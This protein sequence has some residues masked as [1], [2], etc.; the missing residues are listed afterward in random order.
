MYNVERGGRFM[1]KV[2]ILIPAYNVEPY[3][4]QCMDSV[5]NQT[6]KDIEIICINDGSTD[7][8]LEILNEY[9]KNDNRIV[10]VDKINE[11]Y[12]IGMNTAFSKA[13]G[14]YIGIVEPD[15]YVPL[16]MYEELYNIASQNDLDFVKAD[17]YRFITNENGE[18]VNTLFRLSPNA[19][20]YNKVF[21]P[22]E[23]PDAIR[24][25]MNTWSGIY[26]RSFLEENHIL[27]NTTPGASYQ[28]NGFWM[29]TFIFAK[30]AM[31]V[32][33]PYYMNRRDNQNSSVH[34]PNKVY[35]MNIEYDHI[36]DIF[37]QHP[38]LWERFKYMYWYKKY[39]SYDFTMKRIGDEFR[40]E[41]VQRISKEFKHAMDKG[42]LSPD[43]FTVKGWHDINLLIE[44]P[45]RFC[46]ELY[47]K[48]KVTNTPKKPDTFWTKVKRRIPAP[49]K[50]RIKELIGRG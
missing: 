13:T 12:G 25:V 1:P 39:Y 48:K 45:K 30:R 20:D 46:D 6:L 5:V 37:M 44:D 47:R 27:H 32:D 24:F 41:Y 22:S 8:T 33:K 31:I 43:V 3:L 7:R 17:F 15:D 49:L 11:G 38:D 42:E 29:Q 4:H 14:E 35:T 10:V 9:A 19:E 18:Q 36:R 50:A 21:N 28:D 40:D 34:N 26:K 16:E 2:S 23:T